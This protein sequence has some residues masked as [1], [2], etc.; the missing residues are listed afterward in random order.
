MAQN[1]KDRPDEVGNAEIEPLTDAD[2]ES[3]AGGSFSP[4]DDVNSNTANACCSSNT[5]NACC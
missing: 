3:A 4:A 1:E 5:A 2:L